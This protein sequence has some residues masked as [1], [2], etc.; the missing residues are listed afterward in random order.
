MFPHC[1]ELVPG[2]QSLDSVM[3]F[4]R[5]RILYATYIAY[6]M[7]SRGKISTL[8]FASCT[9]PDY[10]LHKTDRVLNIKAP[11]ICFFSFSLPIY[12]AVV[13]VSKKLECSVRFL[14]LLANVTRPNGRA[15]LADRMPTS[16]YPEDVIFL[17]NVIFYK[18]SA[19]LLR[20]RV[21]PETRSCLCP[22]SFIATEERLL[23]V[24]QLVSVPSLNLKIRK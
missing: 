18:C 15:H 6:R 19:K 24:L 10:C 20:L 16:T 21:R 9:Q 13:I 22:L 5:L 12:H 7:R 17:F 11:E 14:R 8:D 23:L 4:P 1:P 2:R 3:I